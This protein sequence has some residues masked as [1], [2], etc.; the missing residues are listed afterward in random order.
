M[1]SLR[2]N[3]FVKILRLAMIFN[4][5]LLH[6]IDK[7]GRVIKGIDIEILIATFQTDPREKGHVL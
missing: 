2:E 7:V 4:A 1:T 3:P 6:G 5:G